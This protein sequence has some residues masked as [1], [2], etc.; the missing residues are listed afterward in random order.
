MGGV[1]ATIGSIENNPMQ[2]IVMS[3]SWEWVAIYQYS[4]TRGITV[5]RLNLMKLVQ[6]KSTCMFQDVNDFMMINEICLC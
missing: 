6:I 2:K 3:F 5:S 4:L 1:S